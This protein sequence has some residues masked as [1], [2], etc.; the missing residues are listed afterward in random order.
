M[1]EVLDEL[2]QWTRDGEDIAIAT[3]TERSNP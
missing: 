1:R 2:N 3:W